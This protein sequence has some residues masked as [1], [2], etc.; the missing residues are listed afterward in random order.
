MS[1][2]A[3]RVGTALVLA[4]LAIGAVVLGGWFFAALLVVAAAA[5][6]WELYGLGARAGIHVLRPL[7]L[8][9]GACLVIVPAWP[10]ALALGTLALL[11]L[12]VS[13]LYRRQPA[14]LA[15]AAL[16]VFG[17]FY[18]AALLAW[19]LHL[20][21]A[22]VPAVGDTG[23]IWLTVTLFVSIWAADTFAYFAGRAFGRRKLFE[24]VSPKKTIEGTI[25][26]VIGAIA[27]VVLLQVLVLPFIT[28]LDAVVLAIIAGA[29]GPFGDLLESLFKRS[30]DA[31]D[32]GTLLPGHGGVLDR[33]DAMIV[34]GPLAVMYLHYVAR[35]F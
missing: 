13:E 28:I 15:A 25:G 6:Q 22:A 8:V 9:A 33:I 17:A 2:L 21:L 27:V 24:R 12:A 26:G 20:R 34:A 5:A 35:I 18:P 1:D 16:G 3:R 32:S 31:K 7:G 4:P 30:V 11:A 14:P 23:A 10:P 19:Y 29:A